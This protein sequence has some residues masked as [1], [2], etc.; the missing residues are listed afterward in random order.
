MHD[1]LE[2]FRRYREKMNERYYHL[3]ISYTQRTSATTTTTCTTFPTTS[4][5]TM[6][7][8]DYDG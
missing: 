6:D 7:F 4:T 5:S 8:N 1:A 2:E 3:V